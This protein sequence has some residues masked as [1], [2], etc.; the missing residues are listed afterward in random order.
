MGKLAGCGAPWRTGGLPSH[1]HGRDAHARRPGWGAVG[2]VPFSRRGL[3][4]LP[5]PPKR[6][7]PL[8]RGA[9]GRCPGRGGA[10]AGVRVP[11]ATQAR[12]AAAPVAR[13]P[14]ARVRGYLRGRERPA[15][16]GACAAVLALPVVHGGAGLKAARAGLPGRRDGASLRPGG[17]LPRP[18]AHG[19][20]GL[21][22]PA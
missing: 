17:C 16:P 20:P 7:E 21:P 1:H 22:G 14:P 6:W 18:G 8:Q 4:A 10:S 3:S 12:C 11:A 5:P 19:I 15:G 9:V 13:R 2:A